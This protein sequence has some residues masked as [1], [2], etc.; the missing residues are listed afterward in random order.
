M[1]FSWP[2][3]ATQVLLSH[4]VPT[5]I[6]HWPVLGQFVYHYTK[7]PMRLK[8]LL[9]CILKSSSLKGCPSLKSKQISSSYLLPCLEVQNFSEGF[10]QTPVI[11]LGLGVVFT[12]AWDNNDKNNDKNNPHLYFVNGAVLGDKEQRVGIRDKGH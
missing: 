8:V 5:R 12:F 11:G 6:N 4:L 2:V 9:S 3:W 7:F 1:K 10:C